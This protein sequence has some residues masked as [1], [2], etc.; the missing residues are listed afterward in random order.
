[1][2]KL[3]IGAADDADGLDN[4]ERLFFQLLFQFFGDGKKRRRAERIAG[5]NTDGV[6]I[7]DEADGDHLIFAVADHLDF[8][9][10][11]AENR[12]FNQ[13]LVG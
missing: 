7:F 11:P 5:M 9:L 3:N 6:D 1:M 4:A 13:T 10:F 12:L 8:Q 2:G